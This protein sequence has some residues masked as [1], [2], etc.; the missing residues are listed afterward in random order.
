MSEL[1]LREN[2]KFRDVKDNIEALVNQFEGLLSPFLYF[3]LKKH[4]KVLKQT[5]KQVFD[6]T[7][8]LYWQR[9]KL[10][11]VLNGDFSIEEF[12]NLQ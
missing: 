9:E 6:Y 2:W 12:K 4:V 1:G 3:E 11:E 5:K 10:W 8:I 7:N